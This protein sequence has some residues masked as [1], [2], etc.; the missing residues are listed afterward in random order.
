M[1]TEPEP[2]L[3]EIERLNEQLKRAATS[4]SFRYA[5]LFM[6]ALWTQSRLV[7]AEDLAIYGY[8]GRPHERVR[9]FDGIMSKIGEEVGL[10]RAAA[11]AGYG[12]LTAMQAAT[13]LRRA[14]PKTSSIV[15]LSYKP[16]QEQFEEFRSNIGL[17]SRRITPNKYEEMRTQIADLQARL[18]RLEKHARSVSD[19]LIKLEDRRML[20]G[21]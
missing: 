4:T 17:L 20:G 19:T 7:P 1:T 13:T 8:P 2:D 14:S 9:I 10:S 12:L 11:G 5:V 21:V 16:T 6:D 18:E 15:L 3:V